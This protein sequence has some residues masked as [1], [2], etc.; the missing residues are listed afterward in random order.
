MYTFWLGK[1]MLPVTPGKLETSTGSKNRSISM[2]NEGEVN[3]LKRPGLTQVKFTALLPHMKYPFA[4][5]EFRPMAEYLD[6]FRQLQ[7]SREPFQ[8]IV[9]RVSPGGELLFDTNLTV[10]MEDCQVIED[11]GN[12]LDIEVNISLKQWRSYSTKTVALEQVSDT[13]PVV[14]E[15]TRAT[16][17]PGKSGSSS[18][19]KTSSKS[20]STKSTSAARTKAQA[21]SSDMIKKVIATAKSTASTIGSALTTAATNAVSAAKSVISKALQATGKSQTVV[22]KRI[23]AVNPS[24]GKTSSYT[25]K[26]SVLSGLV[27]TTKVV[28]K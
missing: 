12:G 10:S 28:K 15:E 20:K 14:K 9:S 11:A 23:T 19:S 25:G 2:I 17:S 3:L 18:S 21:G 22:K 4:Q 6:Y 16:V 27:K 7:E 8:F 26:A 24:T 5:G 1:T 13:A